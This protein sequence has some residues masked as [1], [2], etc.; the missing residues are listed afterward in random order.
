[1]SNLSI[2]L[3]WTLNDG[4][5]SF[6]K[7]STDHKI[8]INDQIV[9]D[10][11]SAV[12]YGGNPNNLNPE[13]GLAAAM[14]SC[15]MMT[16]L[17]LAAKMKWPVVTYEDKA[18][19]YLDKNSNGKMSV[20]KIELNPQI[21]FQNNFKVSKEELSTMHDRSHRYC[22]IANSLSKEVKVLIN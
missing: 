16:F 18:V 9:V 10:A 4:E 12:E 17:A 22:F 19:A 11:S 6:G 21:T 5:L 8:E 3:I 14:S 20:N 15:H 13:Q 7:Y 1:M 2:K